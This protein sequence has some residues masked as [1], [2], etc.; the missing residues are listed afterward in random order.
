MKGQ[1][2]WK[3]CL[4]AQPWE[5]SCTPLSRGRSLSPCRA[6]RGTALPGCGLRLPCWEWAMSHAKYFCKRGK[7]LSSLKKNRKRTCFSEKELKPLSLFVNACMGVGLRLEVRDVF[8]QVHQS[9]WPVTW[10]CTDNPLWSFKRSEI[11]MRVWGGSWRSRDWCVWHG[12]P[13]PSGSMWNMPS[14][15]SA[16]PSSAWRT[17]PYSWLQKK[18]K[19]YVAIR[20][21]LCTA[22]M[23]NSMHTVINSVHLSASNKDSAQCFLSICYSTSDGDCDHFS[24]KR[25]PGTSVSTLAVSHSLQLA[26]P[27]SSPELDGSGWCEEVADQ[28]SGKE[29]AR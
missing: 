12:V 6:L 27:R 3:S 14:W 22:G 4:R 23:I 9:I 11:K 28:K 29:E 7:E 15:H 10:W 17:K 5:Q 26:V 18:K 24:N 13:Y 2:C 21:E 20:K 8:T 19:E 1:W 16:V 25:E